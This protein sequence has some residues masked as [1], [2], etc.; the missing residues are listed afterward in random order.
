MKNSTKKL[1]L[2]HI[3]T[4]DKPQTCRDKPQ[5]S[6]EKVV[7]KYNTVAEHALHKRR[8]SM[9]PARRTPSLNDEPLKE[10]DIPPL[11]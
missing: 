11:F 5:Y 10:E 2:H 7:N 8:R 9:N 4:R 6:I 1:N 3:K